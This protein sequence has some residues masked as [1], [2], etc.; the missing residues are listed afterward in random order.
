MNATERKNNINRFIQKWMGEP[1]NEDSQSQQFWIDFMRDVCGIDDTGYLEFERPVK[2]REMDGKVHTRKIDVYVPSAKVIIEMKGANTDLSK[3]YRQSG[4]DML[5]SYEQAKRYSDNIPRSLQGRYIITCNFSEFRIY[6]LD[7]ELPESSPI[8]IGLNEL[9][10]KSQTFTGI[11]SYSRSEQDIIVEEQISTRAGEL[12]GQLYDELKKLYPDAENDK[13]LNDLILKSLN[14]LCVRFVFLFYAEDAGLFGTDEKLFQELVSSTPAEFLTAKFKTLFRVL[15]MR[16]DNRLRRLESAEMQAF[17]YVN[18]GLFAEENILIPQ[19]TEA[20]RE[21]IAHE[22]AEFD[23]SGISPTIFGAMFESTISA[24]RRRSGGMHYTSVENIHKI[25]DPLFLDDL[26]REMEAI[27]YKKE[28]LKKQRGNRLTKRDENYLSKKVEAFQKK[29]SEIKILDPACGSGNFLTES[30]LSLR[31]LENRALKVVQGEQQSM[32][33]VEDEYDPIRVRIDQFYGIEVGGFACDVARTALWI[34]EAQMYTETMKIV[35]GMKNGFLPLTSNHNIHK[36]NALRTDWNNIVDRNSLTYIIGNPPFVGRRYRS[37]EQTQDLAMFFDYKD[38][39]YVACWFKKSFDF[40]DKTN[41]RCAF[42]STN[43]ITQG[44]QIAPLWKE[45]IESGKIHIDFAYQSFV[46]NNEAAKKAHVHCTIIGFSQAQSKH[47]KMLISENGIHKCVSNISPYLRELPNIIIQSTAKPLFTSLEM[48]NGNVPLDGDALK[49]EPEDYPEFKDCK[50]VKNLMGG[51][52]LLHGNKRYVLWL[53][54]VSPGIIQHDARILRRVELCREKRL[55][56]KDNATKRLASKPAEFRDTLNPDNYIAIPTVSSEN[57]K[58]IP[59]KYLDGSTIPTNQIQI[60]PDA[61]LYHFG[62][63]ISGVHMAWMRAVAGRLKSDYRYSKEI[64]YNT[65]PWPHA[66][67]E[68]RQTIEFFAKNIIRAREKYPGSSLA[69][70]YGQQ[71][72]LYPELEDA[73]RRNDKA[74]MNLYGFSEDMTEDDIV[75]EL[76]KMYQKKISE[77]E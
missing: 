73:H 75:S 28:Q 69:D 71:M 24:K 68:Q 2:L 30:Y 62:I 67:Q 39:D 40:I 54:G 12:V 29:L 37:P 1:G 17:P 20:V 51:K 3:R 42:V 34:A 9:K 70:M 31:R 33:F 26:T 11:F 7:M 43:S 16:N 45:V 48:R 15:N 65:F 25:I 72:Y 8:V 74:V 76:M 36:E 22:A 6:D 63:L 49:I 19:M 38:I 18:G 35:F 46:W 5:T 64:V 13:E 53:V 56:M 50:Y 66:T 55:N 44:E 4:G 59:M 47:V 10:E 60:I 32:G 41:I 21:F 52:E 61:G 23:W 77:T 27:E 14:I 58:Y 57:R